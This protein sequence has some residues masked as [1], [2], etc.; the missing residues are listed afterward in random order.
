M[1]PPAFTAIVPLALILFSLSAHARGIH[2][3]SP[4]QLNSKS[5]LICIGT[6]TSIK[7]VGAAQIFDYDGMKCPE[8]IMLAKIHIT[9]VLKG[10]ANGEI[11]FRYRA[12][13]P[14][15]IVSQHDG[16]TVSAGYFMANGPQHIMLA[17]DMKFRFFLIP[18][19]D[20]H[21]YRSVMEGDPDDFQSVS[22]EP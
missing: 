10:N 11:D 20:S 3:W 12:V 2:P 7:Q 16:V 19:P 15:T 21:G 8:V 6:V 14:P 22:P 17:K 1:K 9:R 4:D 13:E 5:S 18:A